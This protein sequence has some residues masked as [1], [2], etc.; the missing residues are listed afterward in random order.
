MIKG[1]IAIDGPAGAGK[2]TVARLI[3]K[4]MGYTYL[5]TGAMYRA[6]TDKVIRSEI[7]LLA[8]DKI[9]I[10]AEET[11]FKLHKANGDYILLVDDVDVSERLRSP[12][13]NKAVSVV[14]ENERV[15]MA[16]VAIQ[17]E[18][19]KQ[20]EVVLDGRDIG[21]F[22]LPDAQ[23]K[24]FLDASIE[25]RAKR[26]YEELVEKG[27]QVSYAEV[28]EEVKARDRKDSTRVLAPLKRA[29]DAILIDTS[30]LEVMEV[31]DAIVS[32]CR[33]GA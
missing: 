21:S 17:R 4:E 14:A 20:G 11:S 18:L 29:D 22:V 23:W 1:V 5:D 16:L 27:Y 30:N 7:S 12:E 10:I 15:R 24:F 6:I 3:A 2:S 8:A 9:G 25:E 32:I 31:V 13:V 19:A 33:R 28:V 26:R